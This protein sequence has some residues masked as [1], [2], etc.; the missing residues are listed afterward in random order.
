M[1]TTDG[2]MHKE[3]AH[4]ANLYRS[5]LLESVLPFWERNSL[6]RDCGGYFTCLDR[7]GRVYDT[8]KFVWL[9]ARQVWTFSM[10]YNRVER[11][12]AWLEVAAHGARFLTEHGRDQRGDY[13][14]ALDRLGRP[15]VAPYSVF[16]DCF[17]AMAFSQYALAS[18]DEEA[19]GLALAAF[20]NVR[21]RRDNPKGAYS[22]AVPG[23][24]PL[25]GLSLPMILA[26]VTLELEWLLPADVVRATLA[27]CEDLVFS[28]FLDRERM[29][30]S[31]HVAPDGTLVDCFEGR[32]LNPGH[33]LEAMWFFMDIARR[34]GDHRLA[35]LATDVALATLEHG[36]DQEHGGIYYF[37]DR[38]D[39]PPLALEW[40]QKLWWVHLETLVALLMGFRL[41][42]RPRCLEWFHLVHDYTW[43]HFPDPAHGEWF[44]YLDREGRVLLDLK[45]G[46]W[47]G[48]FHVPR[49]LLLCAEELDHIAR[50]ST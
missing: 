40:N 38:L 48:C 33:G 44:G 9:Q 3:L 7:A 31:E 12:Q 11:R 49:S 30:L 35:E 25:M 24:R 15:L 27:E 20:E 39:R 26:N 46:K 28:R 29:L 36:W 10:L 37:L 22:K 8:D 47:K 34:R 42:K 43:Q 45:G 18:G 23:T 5:N 4:L 17:A 21:R 14:F 6:D 32:L 13:Y 2:T 50:D 16:S 1:P 19:K 41:T